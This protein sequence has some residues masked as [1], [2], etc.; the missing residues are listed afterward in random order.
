MYIEKDIISSVMFNWKAKVMSKKILFIQRFMKF[1]LHQRRRLYQ[2]LLGCW[3]YIEKGI[4]QAQIVKKE[5]SSVKKHI[6]PKHYSVASYIPDTVKV[7][8]IR[9]KLKNILRN[10][11]SELER[12]KESVNNE[13]SPTLFHV[14]FFE[15]KPRSPSLRKEF[16]TDVLRILVE[17]SLKDNERL[18][19][20][21]AHS[22]L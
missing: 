17:K 8:Y 15:L 20:K 6:F 18:K 7:K 5:K 22:E 12:Y 10:Y 9:A 21:N 4:L 11:I 16:S 13:D 19:I 2:H 3:N 1:L 14:R